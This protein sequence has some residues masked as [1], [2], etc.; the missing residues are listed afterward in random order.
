MTLKL[1]HS[2]TKPPGGKP[3]STPR[4]HHY[5]RRIEAESRAMEAR[6]RLAAAQYLKHRQN[7]HLVRALFELSGAMAAVLLTSWVL[8]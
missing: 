1:V 2:A 3:T 4:L 8:L 6:G 5:Q 7:W